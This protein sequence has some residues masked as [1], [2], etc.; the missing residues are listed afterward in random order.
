MIEVRPYEKKFLEQWNVF[1]RESKTP[2]FLFDRGFMEYHSDRFK[3]G[4]LMF[5]RN[6]VLVGIMPASIHGTQLRSH[7]GLTYGGVLSNDEEEPSFRFCQNK[8]IHAMDAKAILFETS[9]RNI[10]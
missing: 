10:C 7:G 5:F 3:D 4:S 6:G 2:M 9:L 8:I 1:V